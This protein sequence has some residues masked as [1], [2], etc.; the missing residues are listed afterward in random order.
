MKTVL[1]AL[2][3]AAMLALA[4]SAQGQR[5]QNP[6][7]A[8]LAAVADSGR[9]AEDIARDPG[10]RPAEI[11]AFARVRPGDRIVEL[12]PGGGYFSFVNINQ[13][14]GF[15]ANTNSTLTLLPALPANAFGLPR[16]IITPRQLQ[17][18]IKFDF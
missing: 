9:P 8:I 10:R 4:G 1:Y 17:L 3:I 14:R 2:A 13:Y 15:T 16:S 5:T 18:A 7:P 11:L 12:A 6:S